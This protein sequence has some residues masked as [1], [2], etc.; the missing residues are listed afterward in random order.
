MDDDKKRRETMPEEN[1]EEVAATKPLRRAYTVLRCPMNGHQVC[2]CRG[3][4]KPIEG[5]GICGRPAPHRLR[6]R[7]QEAIAQSLAG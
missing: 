7:F 2:W 1:Q 6:S 4:C 5:L 3:L